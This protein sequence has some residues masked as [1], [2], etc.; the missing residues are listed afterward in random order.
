MSGYA[1]DTLFGKGMDE[2]KL[3]YTPKPIS[4][5]ELLAKVRS[6]LDGK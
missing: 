1:K 6:V 3:D 5:Q 4:P 2:D